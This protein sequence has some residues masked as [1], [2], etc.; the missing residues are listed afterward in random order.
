MSTKVSKVAFC[1]HAR[2]LISIAAALAAVP[3]FAAAPQQPVPD[4]ILT[5]KTGDAA[6][7]AAAEDG[8][9]RAG[10]AAV[11]PLLAEMREIKRRMRL[12]RIFSRLGS[13]A[14]P[15]LL[16]TLKDPELG[17]YAGDA[18]QAAVS[19]DA[20]GEVPALLA[21]MKDAALR[22]VCG[23]ALVRATGPKARAH[24]PL[25]IAA[26]QAKASESRLY[27]ASALGRMGPQA[28]AAVPALIAALADGEPAVRWSAAKAL[29]EIGRR[30]KD[31]LP[32]LE[33]AAQD[34]NGDVRR[35]AAEAVGKIKG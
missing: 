13:V 1:A 26:L 5:V 4:L 16:K 11:R 15:E 6:A 19:P 29:G 33:A 27:A 10:P 35:L 9:V 17:G 3:A 20:E 32:A 12:L 14:V 23:S 30:A 2:V 31:A 18:L 34:E 25:L 21:C 22:G 24:V 28:R 8:L 7:R